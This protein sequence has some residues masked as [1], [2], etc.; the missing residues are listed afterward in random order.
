MGG[1]V[2]SD[3]S[4]TSFPEREDVIVLSSYMCV[5]VYLC[6]DPVKINCI[7]IPGKGFLVGV[8]HQQHTLSRTRW[9][10][11]CHCTSELESHESTDLVALFCGESG[12]RVVCILDRNGSISFLREALLSP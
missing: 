1:G 12:V 9:C 11:K 10:G 8:G 4:S 3:T 2:G 6:R 7:F 5:C